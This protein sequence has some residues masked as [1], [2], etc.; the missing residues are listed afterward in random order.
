MIIRVFRARLKPGRRAAYERLCRDVSVPLM[1]AQTGFQTTYIAP[2]R[3]AHAQDFVF[4]SVWRDLDSLRGFAG[5]RWHEA[6][7]L[8]GEAELLE[9]VRVEHYDESYQS[10]VR[11]WCA[12]AE[13][14]RQRE[15]TALAAPLTEA[16]WEAM[17]HCLPARRA[18]K[19]RPRAD[20]RRTL[21]GILYVL[22]NGCRWQD[23]PPGYGN[24]VTCWRRFARWEADGTWERLWTALL[25]TMD[26]QDRQAWALAFVDSRHVPTKRGRLRAAG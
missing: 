15:A 22:R 20:D 24:A 16:Q 14:V 10:L 1:R 9:S 6:T 7:I 26:A 13:S 23:L 4:V 18:G 25:A 11:L 5:E 12:T 21:D 17:R 2:P 19:G 3:E 8:P